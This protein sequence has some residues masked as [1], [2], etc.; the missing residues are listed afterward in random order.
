MPILKRAILSRSHEYYTN[1]YF[2][3]KE[4][5]LREVNGQG[6]LVR[7]QWDKCLNL[8][9]M[10]KG[11]SLSVSQVSETF[12]FPLFCLFRHKHKELNIMLMYKF[13]LK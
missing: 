10:L 12:S 4:P 11:L 7:N 6:H 13:S 1:T 8:N 9:L 3:D 2:I 5:K